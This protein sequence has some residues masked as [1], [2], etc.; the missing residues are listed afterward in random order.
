MVFGTPKF[1]IQSYVYANKL[2]WR[3]KTTIVNAVSS[4]SNVLFPFGSP[5]TMGVGALCQGVEVAWLAP[6]VDGDDGLRSRA[7]SSVRVGRIEVQGVRLD[8]SEH[9][10]GPDEGDDVRGGGERERRRHDLVPR[11]HAE[12]AHRQ[13]EGGGAGVAR[14]RVLRADERGERLL[15]LPRHGAGRD[16]VRAEDLEDLRLLL[17][18]EPLKVD[19]NSLFRQQV[20]DPFRPFHQGHARQRIKDTPGKIRKIQVARQKRIIIQGDRGF[21]ASFLE[22]LLSSY[23]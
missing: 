21:L 23:R 10:T 18:A 17:R 1:A 5:N 14:D 11:L 8:I 15:E 9:G 16:P 4:A 13:V 6:V 7:E 2:A 12:G 19:L 22:I 3:P 20:R